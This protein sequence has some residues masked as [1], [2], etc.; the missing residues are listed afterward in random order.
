MKT[1]LKIF[2]MLYSVISAAMPSAN[3]GC[4]KACNTPFGDF[5]GQSLLTKAYSNCNGDC[6]K[7]E[8]NVIHLDKLNQ[9]IFTGMKW[10]CVE[11]SRRW[12]I[13][14]RGITFA[15]VTYAYHI[16][17]L[18]HG[19]DILTHRKI[20]LLRFKNAKSTTPPQIGDLLLYNDDLAITGHVAVVVGI[21]NDSILVAE[22]NYFNRAWE[23]RDYARRL[24]LIKHKNNYRVSDEA[25]IG[26][27][28]F[29]Q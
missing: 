4:K 28:R 20:P 10:Q 22:Q 29:N 13:E 8:N 12:L 6:V 5:I 18:Q 19:E 26:W 27:V 11:F 1:L 21:E 24:L 3:S 7:N 9:A 17:D 16:W 23:G 14:N 15:E 2:V 25:V